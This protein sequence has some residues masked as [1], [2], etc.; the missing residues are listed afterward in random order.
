MISQIIATL[1]EHNLTNDKKRILKQHESDKT[2]QLLFKMTYHPRF[3][4]WIR[5]S[6]ME[7]NPLGDGT[8]TVDLL[9]DILAQLNGRIVTGNAARTYLQKVI[10]SL[11]PSEAGV[12]IRMINRDM[13]CKV[14]TSLVNDLWPNSVQEFPVMLADKFNEKNAKSFYAAETSI[15]EKPK[16]IVQVKMDGGRCEA[17]VTKDGVISLHSRNGS[18]LLD[19]GV[20]NFLS[21]F[22]G[23]VV[24]GELVSV[25]PATGKIRD[26]KTGNGLYTKM[27]RN[28]IA[29][30]EAKTM[31]FVVWD[32]IPHDDFF[33]GK[34]DTPYMTRFAK[35][36]EI[37]SNIDHDR[38]SVV[39]TEFIH[40]V[41][42]ATSFYERML[43]E[44]EE[45]AML[46]LAEATWSS[47]RV[48]TVLKLKDEKEATLKCV[49]TIPHAKKPGQ[50]GS[51][52]LATE[53]GLLTVSCGSGLTDDDRKKDP[54]EFVGQLVDI[55]FNALIKSKHRD[56]WSMFLP[57][58]KNIRC[59]VTTADTLAKLK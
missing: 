32:L 52:E 7:I 36:A 17:V 5:A 47:D 20:F 39:E 45:G 41:A 40:T 10:S 49:G 15:S 14:S 19:H 59:D 25:D 27:V 26:R 2:L 3:N 51:L 31:H 22:A 23:Y 34:S 30:D 24:D 37:V 53:C 58:F 4:Y 29:V 21:A 46:K 48:K 55:K 9:E 8:I 54:S 57:I 50:I 44:G 12:I 38:I 11:H 42:Q 16:L 6:D 35:L 33:T 56:T 18:T 13:D 28:T 1:K 43:T